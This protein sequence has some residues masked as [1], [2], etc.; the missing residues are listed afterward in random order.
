MAKVGYPL[1]TLPCIAAQH[2][3]QYHLSITDRRLCYIF[4]DGLA[5]D[6]L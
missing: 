4:A 6:E 3:R 2:E 1:G 5:A